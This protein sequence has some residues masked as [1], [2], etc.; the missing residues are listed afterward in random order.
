[1]EKAGKDDQQNN[2]KKTSEKNDL[3]HLS[4]F[5]EEDFIPASFC[6]FLNSSA[7]KIPST[8]FRLIPSPPPW[9]C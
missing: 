4:P 3:V 2:P 5:V 6:C 1:M 7:E 8:P 9:Q